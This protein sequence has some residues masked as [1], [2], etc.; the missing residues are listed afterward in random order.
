MKQVTFVLQP[1][2]YKKVAQLAKQGIP[3]VPTTELQAGY[4]IGVQRVLDILRDGYT[5]GA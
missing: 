5:H 2:Q 1:D 3:L 4:A